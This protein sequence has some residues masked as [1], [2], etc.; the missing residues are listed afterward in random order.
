MDHSPSV[1]SQK[2]ILSTHWG[3]LFNLATFLIAGLIVATVI[4]FSIPSPQVPGFHP[5]ILHF[6]EHIDDYD[7]IFWGSSRIYHH[8]IPA[9][10]D[11]IVAAKT[12]RKVSSFNFGYDGLWLPESSYALRQVLSLKPSRLRWVF[13]DL[14]DINPYLD[15]TSSPVRTAYWHDWH[16]SLMAW[17]ALA[18]APLATSQNLLAPGSPQPR[19]LFRDVGSLLATKRLAIAQ[20]HAELFLDVALNKGRGADWLQPF[21]SPKKKSPPPWLA[22]R[23]FLPEPDLSLQAKAK[24]DFQLFVD[25]LKKDPRP[26][27]PI[28]APFR[29]ALNEIITLV[30]DAGAEPIFV[31]GQTLSLKE[32][33]ADLPEGVTVIR[34]DDPNRSPELYEADVHYD[35]WHLTPRGAEI[36]TRQLAEAF[37]KAFPHP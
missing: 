21:S 31:L 32:N 26:P 22:E 4:R 9:Q 11:A 12:A 17:K 24:D 10:F 13:F 29:Q 34:F 18:A 36:Q 14:M 3:S 7:T 33:F 16:H 19:P 15:L 35:G 25:N 2:K 23:G 5:K 8:I 37:A 6:S 27:R 20:R 1:K 28:S 30:R